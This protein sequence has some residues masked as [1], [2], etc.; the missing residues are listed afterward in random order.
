[1]HIY[2]HVDICM[3][4]YVLQTNPM[5]ENLYKQSFFMN[6]PW[7]MWSSVLKS[8]H[9][10]VLAMLLLL[11]LSCFSH[12]QLLVTPWTVTP[13]GSSVHGILQAIILEWVVIPF[14]R[15]SSQ[16]RDQTQ[17]SCIS[18]QVLYHQLYLG[19]TPYPLATLLIINPLSPLTCI[20]DSM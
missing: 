6:Q 12:V 1:M 4:V 18:R 20:T 19:S 10:R 5:L 3:C 2:V 13:P 17:V 9:F 16:S 7:F 14:S 11:L 15:G 8:Y